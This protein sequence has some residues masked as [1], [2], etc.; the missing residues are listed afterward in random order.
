MEREIIDCFD[1]STDGSITIRQQT[2]KIKKYFVA[3]NVISGL[4]NEGT[5]RGLNNETVE[6]LTGIVA[7]YLTFETWYELW[8]V[9]QDTNG[10]T[11]DQEMLA[12]GNSEIAM[13]IAYQS[14]FAEGEE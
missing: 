3:T 8:R 13:Y 9:H 7:E 11:I 10:E 2:R 6:Y 14:T 4:V 5:D 12:F 1:I